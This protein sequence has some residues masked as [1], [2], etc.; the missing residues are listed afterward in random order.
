MGTLRRDIER[1]LEERH[2]I[3]LMSWVVGR[4]REG[5]SLRQVAYE[6]YDLTGL[7]VSNESVRQW[8][9]DG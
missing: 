6:L 3:T 9:K 1:Q 4:T 5:R 2:G 8:L 7:Y